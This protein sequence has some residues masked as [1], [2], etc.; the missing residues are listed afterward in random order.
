MVKVVWID[1]EVEVLN[2]IAEYMAND[3]E[4]NAEI[5]I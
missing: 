3:S 5:T 4:R 1:S 2:D